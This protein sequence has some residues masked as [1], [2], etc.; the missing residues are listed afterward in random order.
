M[1]FFNKYLYPYLKAHAA[2]I[3][4]AVSLF[5]TD[6]QIDN[7]HALSGDQWIGVVGA[8]LGAAAIVAAVPNS[9]K[10]GTVDEVV[11]VPTSVTLPYPGGVLNGVATDTPVVADAPVQTVLPDGTTASATIVGA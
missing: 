1:S 9:P 7:G 11:D 4:A 8:Y 5:I 3:V 10:P 6:L 2:G